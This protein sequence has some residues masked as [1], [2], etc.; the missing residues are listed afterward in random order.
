M[1]ENP[2][3]KAFDNIW[4]HLSPPTLL[5]GQTP[6]FTDWRHIVVAAYFLGMKDQLEELTE[7]EPNS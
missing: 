4:K 3:L 1:T 6:D 7:K 5:Y 2:I